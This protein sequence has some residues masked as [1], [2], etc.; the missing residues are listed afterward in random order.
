MPRE[1]RK[2]KNHFRC[3]KSQ[4]KKNRAALKKKIDAFNKELRA[5]GKFNKNY[6]I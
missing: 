3:S 4:Q 5:Q 2:K 1:V 6:L